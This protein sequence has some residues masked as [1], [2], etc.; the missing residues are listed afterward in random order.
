MVTTTGHLTLK[1]IAEL[2]QVGRPAVS[3]WRKRYDNFPAPV[4]ESTPR[5]PLFEAASVIDWLKRNDFFPEDAEQELQITALWAV[6]NLLRGAIPVEDYPLVLL[7]LLALD[8]DPAFKPSNEFEKLRSRISAKTI[9]DV[10]NGIAKLDLEDYGKA[11]QLIVDR[12]LGIGSRGARSQYG[13]SRSLSSAALAAS[14]STTAKN[15]KTVLDPAC[16]IGGTLLSVGKHTPTAQLVGADIDPYSASLARLLVHLTGQEASIQT[17]DSLRH[18]PF[19]GVQADLIVCEPPIGMRIPREELSHALRAISDHPSRASDIEEL[20]LLYSVQH[21][22]I[23]GRAYVMTSLAPT[24]RR[25]ATEF[26][27]RLTAE[28]HIE[29]VVELPAGMFSATR[30]RAALWILGSRKVE[31]PLLIDASDQTPES[32]PTRIAEWL[33][34]AHNNK[35][36]DVPYTTVSLADVVTNDGSLCPS[37]YLARAISPQEAAAELAAAMHSMKTTT[38]ELMQFCPPQVNAD[39]V[40]TFTASITLNDLI[41]AGHFE[42]I[43]GTYIFDKEIKAGKARLIHSNRNAAPAFVEDFDEEDVLRPGDII[44]PQ[45]GLASAWVHQDDSQTWVPSRHLTVLRASTEK[46]NPY[47]IAAC[48]NASVNIDNRDTVSRRRP[49]DRLVI[50]KLDSDQQAVI[51]D[52]YRSLDNARSA[53]R[54]LALEAEH[55]SDALVNLVFAGK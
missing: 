55:A 46:Y 47:F 28:G 31:K 17:G 44:V 29:A 22:A 7:T 33:I 10:E 6:A 32:V 37:T 50:P 8:K 21:L 43:H 39:A 15:V 11:A 1:D 48:L 45:Y 54:Q 53:A 4:E 42:R 36:T 12:F 16:G 30:T 13:T 34:A 20:F 52:A 9:E 38:K 23:N 35:T 2:A 40:P 14:A 26:R 25:P 24:F 18:D 3:N 41:K 51:A 19:P 49:T 27:Q 5:K